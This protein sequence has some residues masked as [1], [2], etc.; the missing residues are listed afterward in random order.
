M[1]RGQHATSS[2]RE[3]DSSTLESEQLDTESSPVKKK[4]PPKYL[5]S[6][7]VMRKRRTSPQ[8]LL[9]ASIGT[10]FAIT[11]AFIIIYT[12]LLKYFSPRA[13]HMPEEWEQVRRAHHRLI[14][15][16]MD[17]IYGDNRAKNITTQWKVADYFSDIDLA[18][19]NYLCPKR[20]Q[21][22]ILIVTGRQE[23]ERRQS[24]RQTWCQSPSIYNLPQDAWKC[25]FLMG[26]S[27]TNTAEDVEIDNKIQQEKQR[28]K[29]ILHGSY[30]DTYRNLTFKVLHGLHWAH[31]HCNTDFIL[32]TDD[33]CFVNTHL[34]YILVMHHRDASRMYI[35]TVYKR[36]E[37]LRVI[38]NPQS[39]WY[40]S[41]ETYSEEFYPLYASGAGYLLSFDLVHRLV[42]I[43]VHYKPF[44]NE[45]AFIG[46]LADDLGVR[47]VHSGRFTL[48]NSGWQLCNYL[49]LLV[50]HR[51]LPGQQTA[52]QN[53]TLLAKDSNQCSQKF[54]KDNAIFTWN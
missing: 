33:D 12:I 48:S 4:L 32:K 34:L 2:S 47:P 24:I 36:H 19:N 7:T 5:V 50:V 46:V 43:S 37:Q 8:V 26:K 42:E 45:D 14:P 20:S 10:V 54:D 1:C 29:D 49:Y 44:P 21:F 6:F 23:F 41:M 40:V 35:G 22:L 52:M 39:R 27:S 16:P 51:V 30:V 3:K 38:R 31:K 25:V 11:F 15:R 28:Y 9:K 17:D 13:Q 18:S 53:S